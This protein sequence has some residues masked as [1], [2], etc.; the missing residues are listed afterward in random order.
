VK[1]V[2]LGAVMLGSMIILYAN[3]RLAPSR[4]AAGA[5]AFKV[6]REN[7]VLT[8]RCS[9]TLEAKNVRTIRAA[10][11]APIV[12]RY[13]KEGDPV[14]QGQLLLQLNDEDARKSLLQRSS[15]L[16]TARADYARARKEVRVQKNLFKY[17]AVPEK[18]IEDAEAALNAAHNALDAAGRE[19]KAAEETLAGARIYAPIA[20]IV[21]KDFLTD[22][23][24]TQA[25][26]ETFTVGTLDAFQARVGIDELDLAKVKAGQS[27]EVSVEAFGEKKLAGRVVSIAPEAERAAFAKIDA[28]IELPDLRGLS[29]KPNLSV[30]ARI[31]TGQ[32]DGVLTIPVKAV[33][34]RQDGSYVWMV[35]GLGRPEQRL[36]QLGESTA[37]RVVVRSGLQE[38]DVVLLPN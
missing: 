31:L 8:V 16:R 11:G 23:F 33:T 10:L 20:G 22:Q 6:K 19:E 9:G 5:D 38:G 29:L 14:A 36:V 32:L 7:L 21:V 13:V 25:G 35:N 17:G 26:K 2:R 37:E 30:D 28:V 27:A 34:L 18:N 3:I 12:K 24:M 4:R 1:T 15:E